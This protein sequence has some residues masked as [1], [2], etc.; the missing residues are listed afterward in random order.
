MNNPRI[1]FMLSSQ[2]PSL[3]G[4]DGRAIL[5]HLVVNVEHWPF[6]QPM[7]RTLL[8][9]PHGR[10]TVPDVPNFS[11]AEYGLRCGLPRMI[12]AIRSR[13]L[14]ASA[15]LNASVIDAYPQAAQALLEA[16]WEFIGHGIH[17]RALSQEDGD[18]QAR[19]IVAALDRIERFSGRRPRGWLSPGLRE[20]QDTPDLLAQAGI[21]Y[22]F[23]WCLDDL[24]NWM[25]T[26][27][28]PLLALPYAL[29]LNDSVIHAVEKH[30][31][32]E[33]GRRLERTLDLY[34]E[35]ARHNGRPRVLTLGL[36]PHL[37]GV[38]HRYAD[39]LDMLDRLQRHPMTRFVTGAGIY[40]WYAGQVRPDFGGAQ[41]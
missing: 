27:G 23:D 24:P 30:A 26:S 29:E 32:G 14:P 20:T 16:G 19:T 34:A 41:A 21:D 5:V 40:E 8:T 3:A 28:R 6:D 33:F 13:G 39:L 12:D 4:L 17:Q 10:E 11:W 35:E 7:P 15:S 37:M 9:P 38:P 1:P 18:G 2:R 22:L 25:R 36:H 31:T